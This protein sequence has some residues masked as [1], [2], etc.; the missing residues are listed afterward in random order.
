[1]LD[2]TELTP[3]IEHL[4]DAEKFE[5]VAAYMARKKDT[6]VGFVLAFFLGNFGA[7]HFYLGKNVRGVMYICFFWTLI[8]GLISLIE[9]IFMGNTIRAY[10]EEQA[11]KILSLITS[12]RNAYSLQSAGTP[13]PEIELYRRGIVVVT[14]RQVRVKS[15]SYPLNTITSL[16]VEHTGSGWCVV[17]RTIYGYERKLGFS[18]SEMEVRQL[19]QLIQNARQVAA[20]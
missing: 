8:P 4:S 15:D 1:M 17:V 3:Y 13:E 18:M 11:Q 16:D 9:A 14:N 2:H 7:H 6:M 5:F 10:N 20:S 19:C 12:K